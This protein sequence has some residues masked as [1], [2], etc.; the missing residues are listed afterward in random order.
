[1]RRTL[2]IMAAVLLG[3]VGL[4]AQGYKYEPLPREGV[5][6][7]YGYYKALTEPEDF[8]KYK[9]SNHEYEIYFKGDTVMNGGRSYKKMYMT[10]I[11]APEMESSVWPLAW[12]RESDKRVYAVINKMHPYNKTDLITT[13]DGRPI[14]YADDYETTGEMMLN[15]FN[16]MPGF[17]KKSTFTETVVRSDSDVVIDGY[18]RVTYQG[19]HN[20]NFKIA[21]GYGAIE[22]NGNFL[23]P[24][25]SSFTGG[26][27]DYSTGLSYI[28]NENGEIV[29]K[30]RLYDKHHTAIATV[31]ADGGCAIA[32]DGGYIVAK[33]GDAAA[34]LRVVDMSGAVVA[35]RHVEAGGS[36]S[37]ST[38]GLAPGVYAAVV[39]SPT[40]RA[41][42]KVAVR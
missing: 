8:D 12:V 6:W 20:T 4:Q 31:R 2:L 27:H 26:I 21:E 41:C 5:K 1:M 18:K 3:A 24:Y 7:V 34:T 11:D 33:A 39:T 23:F 38:A 37:V 29:Y 35:K 16:D 17:Y 13:R 40:G 42:Q 30:S 15:D 36:A 32:V 9:K 10:F 28:A 14:V 19:E 22:N 25:R